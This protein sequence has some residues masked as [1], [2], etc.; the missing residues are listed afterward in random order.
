MV[1]FP[2]GLHILESAYRRRHRRRRRRKINFRNLRELT[3]IVTKREVIRNLQLLTR[4]ALEVTFTA[5]DYAAE[6]IEEE[7][8]Y[9]W[10]SIVSADRALS[11]IIGWNHGLQSYLRELEVSLLRMRRKFQGCSVKIYST[12]QMEVG[13]VGSIFIFN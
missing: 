12:D 9:R 7:D 2:F 1:S 8:N 5:R 13:I 10:L 3:R 6:D 11:D 4:M